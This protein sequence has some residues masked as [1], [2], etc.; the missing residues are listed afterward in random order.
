MKGRTGWI[1]VALALAGVAMSL[2]TLWLVFFRV[3][4]D[5]RQGIVQRIFYLHV[6]AA[7]VAFMAF[8]IVALASAVYLWLGDERADMAALSAAE[9]GMVFTAI[10]LT[11]GPLW[12][13]IAWGTY[14]TW[15]PR[16]TLTL[17]LG[18]IYVGYMMVRRATE[19]PE[20][21]K[22]FAA[23]VGI[24]GAIN[25]PLIHMSVYWFRSLHPDP[26]V[27]KPDGPTLDADM[28]QTLLVGLVAFTLLFTGLM[29]LRYRVERARHALDIREAT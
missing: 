6:P 2:V 25:I 15:E 13:K 11:S 3:G 9:G 23:V 16:L 17:L 28:L 4:T 19:S 14:W 7:W 10:V 1:G 18:F 8:G 5:F 12:G 27:L 26:V 24:I 29:I 22:R 21:G 20:R